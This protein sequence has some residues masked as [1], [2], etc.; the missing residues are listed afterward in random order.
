MVNPVDYWNDLLKDLP[1]S[2]ESQCSYFNDRQSR[3]KYFFSY[4]QM[5]VDLMEIALSQGFRRCG[6]TYYRTI[7]RDCNLCISYRLP[8]STFKPSRSQKRNLNKNSDLSF[9]VLEPHLTEQKQTMY[10][11]YQYEQH[12]KRPALTADSKTHFDEEEQLHTMQLQMYTNPLNS[13]ELEIYLGDQLLG[14]GIMDIG[15]ES[16]SL[17][18]FVF[19]MNYTKRSLG[20][21]NILYSIEWAQESAFKYIYLGYFIPGHMKMDYKRFYNPSEMLNQETGEWGSKLPELK[22]LID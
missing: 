22:G 1:D 21:L 6:D 5:P 18:Y 19:D 8:L 9:R 13:R 17:V 12:F 10:L 20:K 11:Q 16:I 7:C 15:T 2:P 14:F 3:M 4:E